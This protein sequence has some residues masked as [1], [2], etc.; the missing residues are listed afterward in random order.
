M[1]VGDIVAVDG[2]N[3]LCKDFGWKELSWPKK[4]ISQC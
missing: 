3:Y 2:T 4:L 1:S